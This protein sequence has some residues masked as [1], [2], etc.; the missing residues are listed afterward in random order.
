MLNNSIKY[1]TTRLALSEI[2]F[3]FKVKESLDL[4]GIPG[5]P[6]VPTEGSRINLLDNLTE[7][8]R[9]NLISKET[10]RDEP[11]TALVPSLPIKVNI[12]IVV[13]VP[14]ILVNA[15]LVDYRPIYI[16]TRDILDFTIMKIKE[17]Y[18]AYY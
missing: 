13:S 4:L 10:L 5:I 11:I 1:N 6:K 18:D 17:Y 9:D 8:F 15:Y 16:D 12:S 2:L 3:G 14:T 7:G